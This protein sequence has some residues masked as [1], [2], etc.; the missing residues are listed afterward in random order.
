MC[1]GEAAF[2]I[3]TGGPPSLRSRV[4]SE[5]LVAPQGRVRTPTGVITPPGEPAAV[6]RAV[7]PTSAAAP[8]APSVQSRVA[9]RAVY[10]PPASPAILL[11]TGLFGFGIT[12]DDCGYKLVGDSYEI[13]FDDEPRVLSVEKGTPADAAGLRSGDVITRIDGEPVTTSEG[14]RRFRAVEPGQSVTFGYT[15]AGVPGTVTIQAV[16]RVGRTVRGQYS[17]AGTVTSSRGVAQVPAVSE[18]SQ[19]RFS[20]TVG[21]AEIEVRG[22][23]NVITTVVQQGEDIIIV[24]GDTRIRIHRVR[25]DESRREAPAPKPDAERKR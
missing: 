12:C 3:V 5:A 15:R 20:G 25:P 17:Y 9:G 4:T 2:G 19:L 16:S 18:S 7:P 22:G 1:P 8:V 6:A 13:F 14:A 10:A 24:T 21:N 11:P 23:S